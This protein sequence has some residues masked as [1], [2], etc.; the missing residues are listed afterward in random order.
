M[1]DL[2]TEGAREHTLSLLENK[3]QAKEKICTTEPINILL[4]SNDD[5]KK[6]I[7][8]KRFKRFHEFDFVHFPSLATVAI[9]IVAATTMAAGV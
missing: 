2:Y 7:A 1:A 6:S 8:E 4:G 3:K 5:E 9:A